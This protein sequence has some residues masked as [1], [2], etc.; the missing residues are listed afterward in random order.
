MEYKAWAEDVMTQIIRKLEKTAPEIGATFPHAAVDGKYD[1]KSDDWWTNGFWPG[2][3]WIA[4]KHSKNKEF[5]NIAKS[6]EEKLDKPL[7]EFELLLHDVG[8]MWLLCSKPNYD[9][10]GNLASRLRLLKSASHLAGRFNLKG[11]FIRAWNWELGWAIIDCLMNLPLLYWATDETG[12]PRFEHIS[13]AH[14]DTV[15][16]YFIREDGSVNHIV[17]FDPYTGDFL[18]VKPGQGARADSA[19]SRGASWGIYGLALAYRRFKTK[20]IL[21]KCQ[22]VADFFIRS[23]PEDYAAPWDF[24]VDFNEETPRDTSA[25]A[26]AACGLLELAQYVDDEK[27]DYYRKNA[28]LILKSLTDNYSN[29]KNDEQSLLREGTGNLPGGKDVNV[30]LIYGDYFYI[31][32]ISRLCGEKEIFW[33]TK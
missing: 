18:E 20:D 6:V 8:F 4:Y 32:G 12:D 33:Y 15:L 21:E 28:Y 31:E 19:W 11:N 22:L 1:N 9:L 27:A 14:L 25:S 3:L 10:N 5:V 29:L 24:Y 26:C 23:L 16:K 13:K 17:S 30:G 7:D 2:I